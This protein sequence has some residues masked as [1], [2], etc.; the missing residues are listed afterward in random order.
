VHNRQPSAPTA[1]PD[2]SRDAGFTVVEIVVA[3]TILALI[4]IPL[5][6]GFSWSLGQT[7]MANQQTAATNLARQR[8]EAARVQASTP[9]GFAALETGGEARAS[10]PGTP[11]E[12]EL[13]VAFDSSINI[14]TLTV[15]VYQDAAAAAPLVSL[16]TV[17]SQ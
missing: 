11:L 15:N 2:R 7:G 3:L 8:L 4:L 12:R 16:V 14:I 6:G 17:V 1:P 5:F 13:L 10:V 9:G